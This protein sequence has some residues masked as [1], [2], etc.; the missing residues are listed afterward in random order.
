MSRR[1]VIGTIHYTNLFNLL[2]TSN[3]EKGQ[4]HN[5][6]FLYTEISKY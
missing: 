6:L 3:K 4:E 1:W 2:T 5:K